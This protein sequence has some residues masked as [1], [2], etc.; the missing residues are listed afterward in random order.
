M[1]IRR[2][3]LLER[4]LRWRAPSKCSNAQAV[5]YLHADSRPFSSTPGSHPQAGKLVG[6]TKKEIVLGLDSGVHLHFP[7]EGYILRKA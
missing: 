6:L 7:R 1:A 4:A 5:K 3:L 2:V